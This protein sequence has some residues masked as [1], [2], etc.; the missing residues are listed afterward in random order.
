[1]GREGYVHFNVRNKLLFYWNRCCIGPQG[2]CL[3][4][5]QI[6]EFWVERVA[7]LA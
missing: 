5:V 3:C 7:I 1:M 6:T 2:G 4:G